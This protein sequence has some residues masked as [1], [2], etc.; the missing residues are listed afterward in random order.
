M[1]VAK[2]QPNH[3][4]PFDKKNVTNNVTSSIFDFYIKGKGREEATF[5]DCLRDLISHFFCLLNWWSNS[6]WCKEYFSLIEH[7]EFI[8]NNLLSSIDLQ[9]PILFWSLLVG[10]SW[11]AIFAC[12][13][14]CSFLDPNKKLLYYFDNAKLLLRG[15]WPGHY[16]GNK[17]SGRF[18]TVTRVQIVPLLFWG[19][20]FLWCLSFL[21]KTDDAKRSVNE[22]HRR[23][24]HR[25]HRGQM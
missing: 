4:K 3:S 5:F 21:G 13:W 12:H 24:R 8:H 15:C 19:T 23:R 25:Q 2:G 9:L 22:C 14:L 1:N 18:L 17:I 10:N 16:C 7:W 11:Q 6:R 20:I